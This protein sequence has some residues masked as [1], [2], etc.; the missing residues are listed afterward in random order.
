MML[1]TGNSKA[2]YENRARDTEREE[3]ST[4]THTHTQKPHHSLS[5]IPSLAPAQIRRKWCDHDFLFYFLLDECFTT[6][7]TSLYVC[8]LQLRSLF[9]SSF[10]CY[11]Y[12]R[13]RHIISEG[14]VFTK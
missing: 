12:F 9:H 2:N 8:V 14:T 7:H 6:V 1:L 13:I 4:H 5:L 10:K 3:R 11:Y